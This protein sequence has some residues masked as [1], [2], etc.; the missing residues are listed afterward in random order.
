LPASQQRIE[1]KAFSRI[2]D[3]EEAQRKLSNAS[4]S[5]AESFL[6]FW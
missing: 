3:N 6:K 5:A 2:G 4:R 1:A